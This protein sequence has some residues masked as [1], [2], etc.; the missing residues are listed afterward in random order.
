MG[1]ATSNPQPQAEP[2]AAP[3]C[4]VV[5]EPLCAASLC[6]QQ[7]KCMGTVTLRF[8]GGPAKLWLS[9]EAALYGRVHLY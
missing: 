4:H 3:R 8:D 2:D 5:N 9:A 6:Q 7:G 1:A